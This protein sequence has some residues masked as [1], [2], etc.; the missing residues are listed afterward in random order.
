MIAGRSDSR[1]VHYLMRK[2]GR[3][4][5]SAMAANLKK[6]TSISWLGDAAGSW[7]SSTM[8]ASIRPCV[9]SWPRAF[10][11]S[12][13]GVIETILLH[14]KPGGRREA[15]RALGE[16]QAPKPTPWR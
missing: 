15:A 11:G 3:E 5:T 2:I 14:G 10:R 16:F 6:M 4:P 12:R 9:S 1:F 7:T 8:P 13:P